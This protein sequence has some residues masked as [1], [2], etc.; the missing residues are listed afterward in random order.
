MVTAQ[1]A[2]KGD[3]W[4][5]TWFYVDQYIYWFKTEQTQ[6]TW[7]KKSILLYALSLTQSQ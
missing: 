6:K 1:P 3:E 5:L 4:D 7:S 2:V